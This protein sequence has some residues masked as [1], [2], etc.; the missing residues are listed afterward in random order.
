MKIVLDTS[1]F[2]SDLTLERDSATRML[3]S[4]SVVGAE[5]IIPAVVLAEALDHIQEKLEQVGRLVAKLPEAAAVAGGLSDPSSMIASG[6]REAE[7]RLRL[8]ATIADYPKTPHAN[9]I[10]RMRAGR[11]PFKSRQAQRDGK[12][13]EKGYKDALLWETVLE[14]VGTGERI[15]FATSNTSDF[16]DSNNASLHE[17]LKADLERGFTHGPLVVLRLSLKDVFNEDIAPLLK[18]K[19]DPLGALNDLGFDKPA[20][21]AAIAELVPTLLEGIDTPY[22]TG[23]S[24][25]AAEPPF[26]LSPWD[27]E[28]AEISSAWEGPSGEIFVEAEAFVQAEV[29][30]EVHR[31]EFWAYVEHFDS[32]PHVLSFDDHGFTGSEEV[33]YSMT[34]AMTI[35]PNEE[36][37]RSAQIIDF[38]PLPF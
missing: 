34:V 8:V 30:F 7:R 16:A 38:T 25:L 11:R 2:E 28:V 37:V 32:S 26:T 4:L 24:F 14:L 5:L 20:L 17:D 31:S 9:V 15:I 13:K 19:R 21:A 3:E 1:V 22:E 10:E 36:E 33:L 23:L 12:N 35:N 18:L 29:H 6:L 27:V